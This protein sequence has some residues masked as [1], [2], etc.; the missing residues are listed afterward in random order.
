MGLDENKSTYQ[1]ET[2]WCPICKC[3][4][5]TTEYTLDGVEKTFYY[6]PKGHFLESEI[7]NG[8]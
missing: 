7:D 8:D 3:Y 5:G 4:A 6:C 2:K 1:T